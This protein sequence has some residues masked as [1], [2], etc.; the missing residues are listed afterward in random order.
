M[1]MAI[2]EIQYYQLTSYNTSEL[3][4]IDMHEYKHWHSFCRY[5]VLIYIFLSR[6]ILDQD[7]NAVDST[8]SVDDRASA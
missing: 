8:Y 4:Q 6:S 7:F 5:K 2:A 3:D 1:P